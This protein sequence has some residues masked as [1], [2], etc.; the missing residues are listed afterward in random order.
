MSSA[1]PWCSLDPRTNR[2]TRRST[3]EV[4]G[5][6][7]QIPPRSR[8]RRSEHAPIADAP[9]T[10]ATGPRVRESY[11][12]ER[13][14]KGRNKIHGEMV[15]RLDDR[16]VTRRASFGAVGLP[17][18]CVLFRQEEK[19]SDL[20]R[21][22]QPLVNGRVFAFSTLPSPPPTKPCGVAPCARTRVPCRFIDNSETLHVFEKS[23]REA[24]IIRILTRFRTQRRR[25][26]VHIRTRS[27]RSGLIR[28]LVL[29]ELFKSWLP[30]FLPDTRRS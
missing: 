6:S 22:Y 28:C 19:E 14:R 18:P 27:T 3:P 12:R 9:P 4:P 21:S 26:R 23:G 16:K 8:R 11:E 20:R 30:L 1:A 17:P 13:E 15:A 7:K 10:L 5:K 25:F 24:P 29:S 2:R